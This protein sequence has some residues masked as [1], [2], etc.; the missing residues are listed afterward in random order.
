MKITLFST[1]GWFLV[2]IKE[3]KAKQ[4]LGGGH[5]FEIGWSPEFVCL[6]VVL[7]VLFV[8]TNCK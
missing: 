7:Y 2:D 3:H 5:G 4:R 6:F 1:K 8:A